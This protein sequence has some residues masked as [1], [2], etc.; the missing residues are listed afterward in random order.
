[1]NEKFKA[2]VKSLHPKYEA[3]IQSPPHVLGAKLPQ[4]G[5]YLISEKD[6][7]LYVGRSDN[8]PKRFNQHRTAEMN[9]AA[10]VRLMVAEEV[11]Y[12]RDY[13][14]GRNKIEGY[15]GFAE[16]RE[17][18]QKRVYAMSFRAVEENCPTRQALLEVY[19]AIA[20]ETP[21]NDFGVH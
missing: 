13:R 18:A 6:K 11:G 9:K 8:I 20:A 3:L 16:A 5:V 7:P 10:L 17:R 14:R 12:V 19:C 4:K 21:F 2:A 15:A 1:M